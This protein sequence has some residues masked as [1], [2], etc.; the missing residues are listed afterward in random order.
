MAAELQL[1]RFRFEITSTGTT[2][3]AQVLK[4]ANLRAGR[5]REIKARQEAGGGMT[6]CKVSII[7]NGTTGTAYASVAD[8]DE[9][10]LVEPTSVTASATDAFVDT[11]VE[12][13]AAVKDSLEIRIHTVTGTGAWTVVGHVYVEH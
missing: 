6:A 12:G 11:P 13:F 8:E 7:T 1:S 9:A 5:V 10:V 4:A 3:A 2:E